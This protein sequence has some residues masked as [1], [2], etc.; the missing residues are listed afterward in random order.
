MGV[1]W[2]FYR[3]SQVS[4]GIHKYVYETPLGFLLGVD[5]ISRDFFGT[6][7]VFL[8]ISLGFPQAS[9][10]FFLDFYAMSTGL[11]LDSCGISMLFLLDFYDMSVG[12]LWYRIPAGFP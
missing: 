6:S 3:I 10:I 12:L 11:L 4:T 7:I 9:M 5:E 1:L 8:W 2:N